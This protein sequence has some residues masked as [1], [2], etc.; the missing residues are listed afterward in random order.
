VA[1][2][3]TT[4]A[5]R[6]TA[7]AAAGPLRSPADVMFANEIERSRIFVY[8]TTALSVSGVVCVA[9][10]NADVWASRV[11][12]GGCVVMFITSMIG[13]SVLRDTERYTRAL[14]AAFGYTSVAVMMTAYYFF[15]WFSAVA[16]LVPIGGIT[17][18]MGQGLRSVIAMATAACGSHAVLAGL[19]IAEILDDRSI[20]MI[21]APSVTRQLVFLGLAQF[22]FV[23]SFWLGRMINAHQLSTLE[24]YGAAV[25][26]LARQQALLQ[27]A[28][29]DLDD[30]RRV[31]NDGR[32]SGLSLGGYR[33]G[34]V[35]GRGAMG[36]V[37]DASKIDS[38]DAAAVKVMSASALRDE[39]AVRRFER[40][41]QVTAMLD[42]P[43][44]ARVI[45]YSSPDDDVKFLA[46]ERLT[47]VTLSEELRRVQRMP[48]DEALA[49]LTEVAAGVDT[50]HVAGI[51][52]RDL[53]PRNIFH[54]R[55]VDGASWKILDF[56]VSKLVLSQGT[57]T[58]GAVVGTPQYM[59]PE[60]AS[61]GEVD[62]R[63]D[64][65][66]LGTIAYRAL[67]GRPPFSGPNMAGVLFAVVNSAPVRPSL[68]A[69]LPAQVDA[70]LAIAMAKDPGARF[71]TAA[72]LVES[73]TEACSGELSNALW[74]RAE[75]VGVD[76]P[77]R[78][79]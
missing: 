13:L 56:G 14:A 4:I 49:M 1:D 19:Q 5:D 75:L 37:Y 30:A 68:A 72:E 71:G 64:L 32:L 62:H 45:A 48:V 61:G 79:V 21:R 6:P 73:L 3:A 28:R 65:F 10:T 27:E 67:T 42:S 78:E 55:T 33:L 12:V 52:H 50:A 35:I 24:R 51:V 38:G 20:A 25:R 36:E 17:W 7:V 54:H 43:N 58:D 46:M 74:K 22:V 41:L 23:A 16:L 31:G 77:W 47:G 70:V 60:Q 66:A 76:T 69:R 15:G 57:L 40:E 53:K 29:A 8:L 63:S 26:D 39:R 18:G 59:A 9:V 44:I 34:A 2:T 11:L